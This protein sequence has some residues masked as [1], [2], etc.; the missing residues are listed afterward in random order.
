[1]ANLKAA[2]WALTSHQISGRVPRRQLSATNAATTP[3]M[4]DRYGFSLGPLERGH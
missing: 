2:C 1:M 3:T 4:A